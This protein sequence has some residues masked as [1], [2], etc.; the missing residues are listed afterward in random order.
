MAPSAANHSEEYYPASFPKDVP[1]I[2]LA[3]ISIAKL[4]DGDET[5]TEMLF[6]VCSH[7]G[8]FY[9]DLTTDS[10]G[11]KFSSEADE[12]HHV[13]KEV[14]GTVSIEEKLAFKPTDATGHL[15]TG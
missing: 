12:L 8:F 4:L 1:T 6:H 11:K 7:E 15:D 14:F 13:V 5:E 10:M 3:I 9:L 2:Q